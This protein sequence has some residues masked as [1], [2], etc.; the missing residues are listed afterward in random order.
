VRRPGDACTV[1]SSISF[2]SEFSGLMH[3]HHSDQLQCTIVTVTG[4]DCLTALT[5]KMMRAIQALL[6]VLVSLGSMLFLLLWLSLYLAGAAR[7]LRF[8]MTCWC[9]TTQQASGQSGRSA[10]ACRVP[11]ILLHWLAPR[12]GS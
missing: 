3:L 12:Y 6:S 9:M 2:E 1:A 5:G 10:P 4:A 8:T 11:T 7:D